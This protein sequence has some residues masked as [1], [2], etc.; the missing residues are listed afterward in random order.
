MANA[1]RSLRLLREGQKTYVEW[2]EA[3]GVLTGLTHSG[4]GK[5]RVLDFGGG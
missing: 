4:K 5:V 1:R 2:Y 3:L